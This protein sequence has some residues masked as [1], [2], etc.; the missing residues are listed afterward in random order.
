MKIFLAAALLGRSNYGQL[1][2]P[3]THHAFEMVKNGEDFRNL[4]GAVD[5]VVGEIC[6]TDDD[7]Y[8]FY[9]EAKSFLKELKGKTADEAIA[10]YAS[11]GQ[12]REMIQ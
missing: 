10:M 11:L 8:M 4:M 5:S 3:L 7:F 12:Y 1:P 2:L 6:E 9:E